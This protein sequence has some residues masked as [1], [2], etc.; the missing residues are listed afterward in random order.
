MIDFDSG[1][2]DTIAETRIRVV[3]TAFNHI[4]TAIG[5]FD[6]Y[7]YSQACFLAIT[8][9][10]E[11]GKARTLQLIQFDFD[12]DHEP[13]AIDVSG[14]HHFMREHNIKAIR[15]AASGLSA[16]HGA[17]RRHGRH[18]GA[19]LNLST[20]ILLFAKSKKWM[21]VR[22]S[23][24]YT[25]V[26]LKGKHVTWPTGKIGP[27]Y[28]YYFICMALEIMAEESDA[29]F[30]S[31]I[32]HLEV[33]DTVTE[34]DSAAGFRSAMLSTLA[35]FQMKYEKEFDPSEL[36]FFTNDSRYD[37]L[38]DE[39]RDREVD[40]D[41]KKREDLRELLN[42]QLKDM[43]EEELTDLPDGIDYDIYK[44]VIV[45]EMIDVAQDAP[46]FTPHQIHPEIEELHKHVRKYL[47]F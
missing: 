46:Y 38:R 45:A 42:K 24:L 19:N 2:K 32:E 37:D 41:T 6:S 43:E 9:I 7:A 11:M 40:L 27:H 15:A 44:D 25:D 12:P 4:T 28:A 31:P 17:V 39:L 30:G 47:E 26:N 34:F 36:G 23:T 16:N 8:A 35:K 21:T 33:E 3:E 10:E 5:L 1:M 20:G 22:N 18:D 29:G 13:K 14:I